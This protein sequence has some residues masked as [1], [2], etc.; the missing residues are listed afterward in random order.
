[1]LTVGC[2]R[3]DHHSHLTT[4]SA[5]GQQGQGSLMVVERCRQHKERN[6]LDHLPEAERTLVQRRLRAVWR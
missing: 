3:A 5:G 4:P 2:S 1:M 6:V